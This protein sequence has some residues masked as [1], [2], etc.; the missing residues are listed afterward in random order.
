M[1][2]RIAAREWKDNHKPHGTLIQAVADGKAMR[3]LMV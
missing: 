1:G 3:D 2:V